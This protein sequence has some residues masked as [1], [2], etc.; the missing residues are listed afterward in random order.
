[1][2]VSG[3]SDPSRSNARDKFIDAALTA[4]AT[5]IV[6][7]DR[8]LLDLGTVDRIEILT[9]RQFLNDCRP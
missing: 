4:G 1:M 5:I 9:A 8:H 7:V 2:P 6:S 3:S